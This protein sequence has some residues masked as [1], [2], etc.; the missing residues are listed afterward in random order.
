GVDQRGERR[1]FLAVRVPGQPF[2][3]TVVRVLLRHL[4]VE[5]V[6]VALGR[7]PV[8]EVVGLALRGLL[9]GFEEGA[10]VVG[11]PGLARGVLGLRREAGD[12]LCTASVISS[13]ADLPSGGATAAFRTA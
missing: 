10:T 12:L 8:A 13:D 5:G 3:Q 9:G 7:G 4:V 11:L 1:P 6:A 2:G